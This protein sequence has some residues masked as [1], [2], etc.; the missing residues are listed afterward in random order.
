MLTAKNQFLDLLFAL[1]SMRGHSLH[2]V[3]T[4]TLEHGTAATGSTLGFLGFLS[5]DEQT[6]V[7]HAFNDAAM[8]ECRMEDKPIAFQVSQTGW[9]GDA[10]RTRKTLIVNDYRE[11]SPTK[12][13]L[14][15]GHVAIERFMCVP[16]LHDGK[17]VAI[18]AVANRPEPYTEVNAAMLEMVLAALWTIRAQQSEIDDKVSQL[19]AS[20]ALL[21]E[22]ADSIPGAVFQLRNTPQGE[23]TATFLNERFHEVFG[24]STDQIRRDPTSMSEAIVPEDRAKVLADMQRCVATGTAQHLR[25]RIRVDGAI[26]HV[27]TH[28][29]PRV[30]PNGA[31]VCN[32]VFFDASEIMRLEAQLLSAQRLEAVGRLAAG[33][34]HEI[35]T[36]MQY[37]GDNT[38][39]VK[40]ASADLMR[41]SEAYRGVVV[42]VERKDHPERAAASARELEQEIDL[43]YL[44][45]AVPAALGDSLEGIARVTELVSAMK[46][47]AHPG[48]KHSEPTDL[49][50]ALRTTLV[51][52]RNEWK[53]VAQVHEELLPNL[54][55]VPAL[56][57]ALNQVW[58]N[59]VV[60]AAHAIGDKV[61]G[62]SAMGTITV[63]TAATETSVLV[64]IRDTGQG[65]PHAARP[66]LFE[67]FFT[68]KPEGK[69]TG[70]GLAI[71]WD[72]VVNKH[73]GKI[74]FETELGVGT[75]FHVELP[76]LRP[77]E[78]EA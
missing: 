56:A 26:R 51:V 63:E 45:Q 40:Q 41:L 4:V 30:E 48:Q 52:S 60:N 21:Q 13:G 35:N 20:D 7:L 5:D 55:H 62:T 46:Q 53:Y 3:A 67:P 43:S 12:R 18:M 8:A 61:R 47:F 76:L 24:L 10:L 29:L 49:N 69:G 11:T 78:G 68:T 22:L 74:W 23:W 38:S 44:Q 1:A 2:E 66:R 50:A 36:P 72:I 32:G 73:R 42:A 75:A 57:S 54:P 70:Q 33:V 31:V 77:E 59:L 9:W 39:F 6:M 34:A 37:I 71:A 65:I 27:E 25:F 15:T 64:T 19:K 58:L 14:P 17:L 28:S 16:L